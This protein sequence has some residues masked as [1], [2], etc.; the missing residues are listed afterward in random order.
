MHLQWRILVDCLWK[1]ARDGVVSTTRVEE[2]KAE[3]GVKALRED[4]W[5]GKDLFACG[6]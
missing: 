5:N 3:Y 4:A 6:G 2:A 1:S